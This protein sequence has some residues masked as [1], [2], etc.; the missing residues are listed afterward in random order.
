MSAETGHCCAARAALLV[1]I[2][3]L[4]QALAVARAENDRLSA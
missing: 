1:R 4:E 3:D 2:Q